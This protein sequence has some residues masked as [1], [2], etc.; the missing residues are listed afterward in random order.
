MIPA[1]AHDRINKRYGATV[2]LADASFSIGLGS[3]HALLGENGAG[4]S[5]VVK[6]LS[7]I[8]QPDGGEIRLFDQ[9]H[10]FPDRQASSRAGVETAFQEIPLLPDLTVTQNLLLPR[11]PTRFGSFLNRGAARREAEHILA[12]MELS[13]IDPRAE[14]RGLEL[15]VRQKVEIAR[16]VSRKPKILILD[17][18][19]AA[20]SMHDVAWLGRRIRDL[21]RKATTVLLVTHRMQEVREFCTHLSILRNGAHVGTFQVADVADDEVFRL[22]MGRPVEATFPAKVGVKDTAAAVLSADE[23]SIPGKLHKLSL[24]IRTGEIVGVAGLQGMGQLAL[25]NALF[26]TERLSAGATSVAGTPFRLTS[27]RAAINAGIGLVPEDRKIQG[28]AL[29]QT[30]RANASLPI[31]R[32]FSRFGLIQRKKEQLAIDSAFAAVNLY[33]QAIYQAAASLSGGN[34]Q[35]IVL[36]K[37]LLSECQILLAYDPTRGVDVGTKQE[38]Y[39]L[40]N[41]FA[42]KGGAVLLYSSEMPELVGLCSRIVVLYA[43]RIEAEFGGSEISEERIGAAMLGA[44]A[45]AASARTGL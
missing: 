16:A 21:Q 42:K 37:W 7:G 23:I 10:F 43:G 8:V 12:E 1:V 40:L 31:I 27:P 26:G 11:E 15:S 39:L 3:M 32:R 4:K 45:K 19:T 5:T 35:K 41:S 14:V 18:P 17:E 30:G 9:P 22:I 28:L 20:L 34:Q 29:N 2:A 33:P 6:I 36:A 38:I 44:S 25:F 24:Q 13:E